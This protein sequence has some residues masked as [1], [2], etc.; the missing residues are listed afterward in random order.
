MSYELRREEARQRAI[1]SACV[2][3]LTSTNV[4]DKCVFIGVDGS[5]SNVIMYR[6]PDPDGSFPEGQVLI[7]K[8]PVGVMSLVGLTGHWYPLSQEIREVE[9]MDE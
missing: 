2:Y 3:G 1:E 7:I 5:T 4:E 6:V 8:R 9:G